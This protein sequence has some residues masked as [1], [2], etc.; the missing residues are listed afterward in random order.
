MNHCLSPNKVF[1][2]IIDKK[3]EKYLVKLEKIMKKLNNYDKMNGGAMVIIPVIIGVIV[4]IFSTNHE[5]VK[6]GDN[7]NYFEGVYSQMASLKRGKKLHIPNDLDY[8]LDDDRRRIQLF[9]L[10]TK[11]NID[12]RQ[13]QVYNSFSQPRQDQVDIQR[14]LYILTT[15]YVEHKYGKSKSNENNIKSVIYSLFSNHLYLLALIGFFLKDYDTDEEDARLAINDVI[16]HSNTID[17][18]YLSQENFSGENTFVKHL[19]SK[20][21]T[22]AVTRSQTRKIRDKLL[23][24]EIYP[25]ND[26]FSKH[27][28]YWKPNNKEVDIIPTALPQINFQGETKNVN[29]HKL[30]LNDTVP[31]TTRSQTKKTISDG[32]VPALGWERESHMRYTGKYRGGKK[33]NKKRRTSSRKK[34]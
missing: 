18:I 24:E 13:L 30:K 5:S 34:R 32:V 14:C 31:M 27:N 19:K 20:K 12:G 22:P 25:S 23:L 10:L 21:T 16:E 33:T 17:S 8:D 15:A 6:Y 28:D 9:E 29:H 7:S 11:K 1:Y 26:K 4:N 3:M 2:D